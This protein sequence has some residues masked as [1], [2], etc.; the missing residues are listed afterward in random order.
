M[1]TF[2]KLGNAFINVDHIVSFCTD[3]VP[4]YTLVKL[5]NHEH[6]YTVKMGIDEFVTTLTN[7]ERRIE[8]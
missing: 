8:A 5:I 7:Q 1:T 4:G 2:V 6:M 3:S